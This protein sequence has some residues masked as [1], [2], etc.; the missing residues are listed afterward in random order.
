MS[1]I[2]CKIIEECKKQYEDEEDGI[3][4]VFTNE[5]VNVRKKKNIYIIVVI[6]V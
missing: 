6:F 3:G 5:C 2:E 1:R 4:K